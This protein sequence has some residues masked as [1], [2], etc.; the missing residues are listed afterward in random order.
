MPYVYILRC[1]DGTL[2]T[3]AALSVDRRVEQHQAGTASKYTRSRRPLT[4]AWVRRVKTWSRA[5]RLEHQIKR[6][7][8]SEKLALV[9]E[10][11]SRKRP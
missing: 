2:Y 4:L 5:L 3:G 9:Q 11:G 8:R 10:D 6:L 7:S 1:C